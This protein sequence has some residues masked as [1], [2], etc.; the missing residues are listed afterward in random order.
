[1]ALDFFAAAVCWVL[2]NEGGAQFT[3]AALDR[4]GPTKYGVTL[5]TLSI[6][7]KRP[8]TA[9]DVRMLGLAEAEAIYRSHY[10]TPL[11]LGQVSSAAVA[12]ASLDAA[13]LCGPEVAAK[14]LQRA[15]GADADGCIGPLTL[16]AVNASVPQHTLAAMVTGPRQLSLRHRRAGAG[17]KR[18]AGRMEEENSA[19]RGPAACLTGQMLI[20]PRI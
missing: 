15:V 2:G 8:C 12:T 14:A 7:R 16:A 6:A 4:G 18:L 13:V 1:M 5:A 9:N 19:I 10:W 11:S 17:A 20:L 3:N